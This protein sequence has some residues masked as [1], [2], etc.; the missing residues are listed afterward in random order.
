[1]ALK[2]GMASFLPGATWEHSCHIVPEHFEWITH[3]PTCI[4]VSVTDVLCF[5]RLTNCYHFINGNA[6]IFNNS[7]YN[8]KVIWSPMLFHFSLLV[9]EA[10][11]RPGLLVDL[12]KAISDTNV[13]VQSGEFDT[14]VTLVVWSLCLCKEPFISWDILSFRGYWLKQNSMSVIGAKL[15]ARL[16][17]R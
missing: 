13:T 9:V 11:D 8:I 2:E 5:P 1:M 14:E 6:G 17:N 7:P 10:A 16:C 15:W 12:V 4:S 3:F